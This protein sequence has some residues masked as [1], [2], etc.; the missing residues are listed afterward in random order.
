VTCLTVP[1]A[2]YFFFPPPNFPFLFSFPRCSFWNPPRLPHRTPV[3]APVFPQRHLLFTLPLGRPFFASTRPPAHLSG[4]T[5]T[6]TSFAPFVPCTF[7]GVHFAW[8]FLVGQDLLGLPPE[9]EIFPFFL[10][11]FR[12]LLFTLFLAPHFFF[13]LHHQLSF[14]SSLRMNFYPSFLVANNFVFLV[15]LLFF[16]PPLIGRYPLWLTV[17]LFLSSGCFFFCQNLGRI[18]PFSP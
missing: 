12:C 3:C 13:P 1:R 7:M 14:Q 11:S 8:P 10:L 15:F 9:P 6:P 4:Y 17:P 5:V 18:P 2:C 16:S